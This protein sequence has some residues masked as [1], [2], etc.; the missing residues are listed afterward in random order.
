VLPAIVVTSDRVYRP[1]KSVHEPCVVILRTA[2]SGQGA[3]A[4]KSNCE[5]SRK[6]WTTTDC[7][8]VYL[9]FGNPYAQLQLVWRHAQMQYYD[10]G[11]LT[12][13]EDRPEFRP[14]H[15]WAM[16]TWTVALCRSIYLY[17]GNIQSRFHTAQ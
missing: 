16:H 1:C 11:N 2:P 5:R 15:K 6:A 3:P 17:I 7:S 12:A 9:M 14:N 8:E 10:S 13:E 4:S